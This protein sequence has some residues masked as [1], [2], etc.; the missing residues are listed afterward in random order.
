MLTLAV[1]FAA[2]C[3][4]AYRKASHATKRQLNHA[5]FARITLRNGYIH[6]WE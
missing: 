4:T 6:Q 3:H 5:I 1:K 2:N